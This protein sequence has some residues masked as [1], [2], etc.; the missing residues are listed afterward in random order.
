MR[1][2][3]DQANQHSLWK[4]EIAV[5]EPVPLNE[6]LQTIDGFCLGESVFFTGEAL[7]RLTTLSRWPHSQEYVG[8]TNHL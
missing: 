6:E 1:P 4:G 2:T 8:N 3:D 7:G 5:H